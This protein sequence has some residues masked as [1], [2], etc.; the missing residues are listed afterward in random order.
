ML[1]KLM[2]LLVLITFVFE[3]SSDAQNKNERITNNENKLDTLSLDFI[4]FQSKVDSLKLSNKNLKDSIRGLNKKIEVLEMDLSLLYGKIDEVLEKIKQINSSVANKFYIPQAYIKEHL[5]EFLDE[6]KSSAGCDF[7]E[8]EEDYENG[9]FILTHNYFSGN[10]YL[11]I[12]NKFENLKAVDDDQYRIYENDKYYIRI[13]E[14]ER[15]K[16]FYE[17]KT[18]KAV[19]L[20]FNED[21]LIYSKYIFGSC[22]A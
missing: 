20:L 3:N 11:L 9:E 10:A 22:G 17:W 2:F 19:L 6:E 16:D 8:S 7:C 15:Y 4:H 1:S 14:I 13:I 21:E 12:N 5:E 18:F